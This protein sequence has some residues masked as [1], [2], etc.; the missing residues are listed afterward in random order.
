MTA[1]SPPSPS[2]LE[3][4][5]NSGFSV[6][7]VYGLTESYGPS[8]VCEWKPEWNNIK[9]TVK[10]SNLKA[11]QGVRYPSLEYLDIFNPKS[12]KPVKRDGKSLGEVFLKGN[13]IM[14][15]YLKNKQANT[16]AF[17][18]GWFHTGDLA[19]MHRDGYIELKDRSKDIIISGGENISS[20][21]IEKTLLTHPKIKDCAV[22]AIKDDKWGEVP[23]A[24]IE[25]NNNNLTNEDIIKFCREHLA[26][27]KVPKKIIFKNLPRTSTG[28]IQK[29]NLRKILKKNNA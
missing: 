6:T 20:I 14:K 5:E 8:V 19:V 17:K 7:H 26:G 9:S 4:I 18:K 15:G 25:K 27:F 1:A 11:R 28:K 22:I 21:E 10:K 16:E 3:E 24:F 13:I 12:M 29:F 2:I 23:C